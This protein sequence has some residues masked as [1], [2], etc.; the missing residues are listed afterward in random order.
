MG[1]ISK[2]VGLVTNP[3]QE[4]PRTI[5]ALSIAGN[6]GYLNR[7]GWLRSAVTRRSIDATGAPVPWYTY[8]AI[9]FIDS[10]LRPQMRVFEYGTGHSTLWF[11]QRVAAVLGCE[12]DSAW[13]QIVAPQ[14]PP[15]AKVLHRPA[16]SIAD[17]VQTLPQSG[18]QFDVVIVDGLAR[19]ECLQIVSAG[20]SEGGVVILDNADQ[21]Q[22]ASGI[23]S[24]LQ[25][26]FRRIDFTGLG[27]IN[28][29]GWTTTVFYR[30]Q[31]CFEI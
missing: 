28:V 27:P 20:L 4:I 14:L 6:S 2:I 10:R 3:R 18:Q 31:N 7:S 25:Q 15:N 22:Y 12:H 19:N 11:A 8:A 23:S 9:D 17:Y 24:L 30:P 21:S 13:L 26:G 16:E 5:A 29:F 1:V